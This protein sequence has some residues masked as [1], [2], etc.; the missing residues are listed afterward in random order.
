MHVVVTEDAEHD[1]QIQEEEIDENAG[2][3]HGFSTDLELEA[4]AGVPRVWIPLLGEGKEAQLARIY[5]QVRPDEVCPVLPSPSVDPRRG[6]SLLMAYRELLFDRIRVEPGNILY[7]S[8]RNPFEVYRQ[9]LRTVESYDEASAFS[10]AARQSSQPCRVKQALL[11]WRAT[12][13]L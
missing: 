4:T 10:E 7:A 9:V 11:D 8:E 2:Y 5:D 12:G 13:F 3:M 1:R 6:D